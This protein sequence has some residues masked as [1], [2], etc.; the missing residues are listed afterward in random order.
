MGYALPIEQTVP[1]LYSVYLLA[2]LRD[3]RCILAVLAT[4]QV[5]VFSV[6]F[7]SDDALD[8]YRMTISIRIKLTKDFPLV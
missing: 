6:V 7:N 5:G 8:L 1:L 4:R 3:F 2:T